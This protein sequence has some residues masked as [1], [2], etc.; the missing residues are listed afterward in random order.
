MYTRNN[1]CM[2]DC[3]HRSSHRHKLVAGCKIGVGMQISH[4]G[5]KAA[6]LGRLPENRGIY[7]FFVQR[8]KASDFDA[9]TGHIVSE[10]SGQKEA[11]HLTWQAQVVGLSLIQPRPKAGTQS[12]AL[13]C[14]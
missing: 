2:Y 5:H 7:R 12:G 9:E 10:V 11:C 14:T 4:Y 8:F 1:V 3:G 6:F 13:R